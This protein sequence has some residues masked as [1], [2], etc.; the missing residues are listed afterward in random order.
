MKL[1]V[2]IITFNEQQ[3]IAACLKAAQTVADEIIVLD[4]FSTDKTPMI[5]RDFGVKFLQAPFA[6]FVEQKNA[7]ADLASLDYI[8]S[9]DADEVLSEKLFSEIK[10]VKENPTYDAY[11]FNRLTHFC[12]QPIRHC[13]W[14]PD[15]KIRLWRKG[16]GRW[17]GQNPHD[18]MI[19]EK[20]ATLKH[21]SGDLLHYSFHSIEQHIA[22]INKFSTIKAEIEFK[23]GK[24]SNAVKLLVQPAFKFF[25]SYVLKVGFL[26]GFYGYIVC[27]NSAHSTF[28]KYAKLRALR[29]A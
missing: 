5:C 25:R 11:S 19:L 21:L 1:S 26:D 3:N 23:K 18:T 6:G 27:K 16:S 9:L 29:K 20:S 4:S 13:G 17:G 24:K 10:K 2:V 12:G 22:Q 14:Y 15:T 7:A 8:L 28:L